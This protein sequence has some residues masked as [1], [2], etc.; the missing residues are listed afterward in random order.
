MV[1]PSYPKSWFVHRVEPTGHITHRCWRVYASRTLAGHL[2]TIEEG[3]EMRPWFCN[4]LLGSYVYR[5]DKKVSPVLPQIDPVTVPSAQ[6]VQ[7][8]VG[9]GESSWDSDMG[10]RIW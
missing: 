3:A 4:L 8:A 9:T 10:E 2:V 6:R 1:I 5:R 7:R